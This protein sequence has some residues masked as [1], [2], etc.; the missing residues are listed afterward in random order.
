MTWISLTML[1]KMTQTRLFKDISTP[2]MCAKATQTG[3]CHRDALI[4]Q[5][6]TRSGTFYSTCQWEKSSVVARIFCSVAWKRTTTL[7]SAWW[8]ANTH[9]EKRCQTALIFWWG[10]FMRIYLHQDHSKGN[11]VARSDRIDTTGKKV[12]FL[13]HYAVEILL[14]DYTIKLKPLYWIY[15]FLI[16]Y[17]NML[18]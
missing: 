2:A 6:F 10:H 16:A 1:Q 8:C 12:L 3:L 9:A 7:R 13:F 18:S 11:C 17:N 4:L 15:I 5:R 14:K